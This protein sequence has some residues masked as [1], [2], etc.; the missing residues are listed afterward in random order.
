MRRKERWKEKR[1]MQEGR[2][3]RGR[4]GKARENGKKGRSKR[5]DDRTKKGIERNTIK[6]KAKGREK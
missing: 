2:K 6:R 1:K 3:D 4:E 5:G